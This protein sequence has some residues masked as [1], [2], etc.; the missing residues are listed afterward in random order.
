MA[1]LRAEQAVVDSDLVAAD[2]AVSDLEREQAKAESDLEPVRER[3]TRNQRRIADGSVPDAKALSSMVEEVDHLKKRIGDLEDA[4]LE[5]MEQLEQA[6]AE[7]DRLRVRADELAATA[8]EVTG[9]RDQ[10]LAELDGEIGQRRTERASIAPTIVAAAAHAVRPGRHQPRRGRGGRAA[11][12]ALH[13]LPARGERGRPSELRRGRRRR[14]AALR[15]MQPDPGPDRELGALAV[16]PQLRQSR[17]RRETGRDARRAELRSRPAREVPAERPR[18]SRPSGPAR[19]CR[20]SSRRRC[21][22][23]PSRRPPPRGCRTLTAPTSSSSPSTREGSRDLDQA[24]HITRDGSG[25]LIS[26]AIADVAAFVAPGDPVDLEAH[27]RVMTL[28]APDR[29]IPLHPPALS[30]G[31]ASLLPDQVRPALLWTIRTRR[32]RPD[33]RRRGGPGPGSQPR[34][35]QLRRGAGGDR[36]R[37]AAGDP[38]PAV[39]GRALAGTARDRARRRE[40][41]DPGA[42]D[43]GRRDPGWGLVF[44]APLPVEGWNAQISL[45]TGMA[46]AHLMLYGQVGVLRTMP[47]ADPGPL[48]RL[49]HTAKA[50]GIPWPAELDYPEFVRSLDPAAAAEAAMLNACT[51]LFRGAGYRAFSGG[52][53]ED[54]EH[55]ALAIDYAH[56]TAPL[57]RLVDRY[58]GEICVALCAD[59]R[60]RTGCCSARRAARGD[61]GGRAAGQ[62]VRAGDHRPGRGVPAPG[63]GR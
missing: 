20:T 26:Y 34:A 59:R 9:R 54:A 29:R 12:P 62:E 8:A 41:A 5:V 18:A 13:R 11:R 63:P 53:P 21:W 60:C 1:R 44:R 32:A 45:L 27:R 10:Q 52:V 48:R 39:A 40:P 46:A 24:L 31:A 25:F 35:A 14:G 49:R 28:Y 15:G 55:A 16:R 17:R 42:G 23:R 37:Y 47:P 2:T 58:A 6:V 7:R 38:G 4:E 33:D 30:E 43:G 3:L 36:R 50:L 57:R 61:G 22:R 19:R 56:V 51:S